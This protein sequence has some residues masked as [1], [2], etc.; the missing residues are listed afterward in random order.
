M[1]IPYTAIFRELCA[2][3]VRYLVV[4]GF[5]VN[6]HQVQRATVDLDLIVDLSDE[7]LAKFTAAAARLGLV[8]RLPVQL[9]QFADRRT[10]ERWIA[11]K[12]LVVFTL[13]NP[14]NVFETV[15]VFAREP[16]PFDE[17]YSRRLKVAAFG[18]LIPVAGLDDLIRMK[19]TAGR[20]RDL[21][22]AAQL[23]KIRHES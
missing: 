23:R 20:E 18:V 22:D 4:G 5:A 13:H 11:E 15:D 7:N 6:F 21:F 8:P 17:M 12:G 14:E 3:D 1:P 9:E 19:E 10:R 16:L 2:A